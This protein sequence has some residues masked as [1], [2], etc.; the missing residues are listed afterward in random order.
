VRMP[1]G[2]FGPVRTNETCGHDRDGLA[3]RPEYGGGRLRVI[4][5][6]GHLSYEEYDVQIDGRPPSDVRVARP[7]MSSKPAPCAGSSTRARPSGW[8]RAISI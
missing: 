4:R 6:G 5:F 2:S 1:R 7:L 8:R 3:S